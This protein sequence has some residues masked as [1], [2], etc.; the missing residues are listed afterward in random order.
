M[1]INI[2]KKNY[3]QICSNSKTVFYFTLNLF[4]LALF[5]T[6]LSLV[7]DIYRTKTN[8]KFVFIEAYNIFSFMFVV[9]IFPNVREFILYYKLSNAASKTVVIR[10]LV[11]RTMLK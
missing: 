2:T 10:A 1:C 6:D 4:K 8:I 5:S 7:Y 3:K 11:F 9:T